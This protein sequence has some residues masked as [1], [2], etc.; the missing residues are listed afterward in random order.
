MNRKSNVVLGLMIIVIGVLYLLNSLHI[1]NIS[2][3]YFQIGFLFSQF[4]AILFVMLPGILM[5]LAFFS[6]KIHAGILVP[7]GILLFVGLTL[8]L[9]FSF[10]I[11]GALWPGFIMC[12]AIGLFEL[13]IF[14][15]RSKGLLIPV[16]ILGSL[17]V[18]FF[19]FT[20]GSIVNGGYRSYFIPAFLIL[21]GVVIIFNNGSRKKNN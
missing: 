19:S 7:G 8:Q 2:T 17:S 5:H 18:V 9:S 11:W 4:W 21:S 15:V 12:V 3:N 20:S 13:Y 10:N 6:G 1:T 14:G 16:G